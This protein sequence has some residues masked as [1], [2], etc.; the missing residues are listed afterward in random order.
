MTRMRREDDTCTV[1]A[2][3]DDWASA[4][5]LHPQCVTVYTASAVTEPLV[6]PE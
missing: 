3:M 5:S 6:P 2:L 1:G 4:H